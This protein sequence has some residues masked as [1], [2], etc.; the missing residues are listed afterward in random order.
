MPYSEELFRGSTNPTLEAQPV[1]PPE[2]I[3]LSV[4][5]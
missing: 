3:G 1:E 4:G 2:E 5:A